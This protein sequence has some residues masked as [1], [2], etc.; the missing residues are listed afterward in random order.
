M[1]VQ[2]EPVFPVKQQPPLSRT[3]SAVKHLLIDVVI[4]VDMKRECVHERRSA[5]SHSLL[6]S[7][8]SVRASVGENKLFIWNSLG[9]K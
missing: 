2:L 9:D 7:V 1:S 4:E 5:V 6:C 3:V 8:R